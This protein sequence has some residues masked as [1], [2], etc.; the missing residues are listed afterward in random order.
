LDAFKKVGGA[1]P[2]Y[3]PKLSIIICGKRHHTRFYPT[4]DDSADQL[5]NSKPGLVA[6]RGVTAIFEFDFF[7]QAHSG[8]QGATRPTHYTVIYDDNK[9]DAD[10]AQSLINYSSYTFARATRAVSLVPPAYY[11][12]LACERG[13]LY[14]QEYLN[15][16]EG[17]VS[18]KSSTTQEEDM[19][20]EVERRWGQG[21][22]PNI[23]STMFY[24]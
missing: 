5:G 15:T 14:I 12:D 24:I 8:L 20:A 4:S 6:D 9:F 13:R 22:H 19:Y 16:P 23:R 18:G 2:S 21:I 11:A 1:G 7:L 3:K 10:V 17:S